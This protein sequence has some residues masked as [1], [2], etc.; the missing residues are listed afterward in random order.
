[1]LSRISIA[2]SLLAASVTALMLAPIGAAQP[3][4]QPQ[5][6]QG[7]SVVGTG[8]VIATPTTARITLGVEVFDASLA[9]AQAEATRRMDAV[10]AQLR[11]AGIPESDIRTVSFNITPQ[12]DTRAPNQNQSVLRGYQIQ[13][14]VE[15]KTTNLAGLGPLIDSAVSAGATRIYGIRFEA[16]NVEA[17][18]AQARDQAMQ[19]ARAKAEQLARDAGVGLGRPV[20]IEESD[21]RDVVPVRAMPAAAEGLAAPATPIQPGELQI[22]T[23]VRVIWASL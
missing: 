1:V 14:L 10:V 12:Y 15:V 7:I 13:N 4:V 11:S 6:N 5:A 19:N 20:F 17:P 8:I 18:K 21:V 9:N 16:E 23:T 22:Q 3:V 2:S